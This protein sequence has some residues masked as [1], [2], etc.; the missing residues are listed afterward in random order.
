VGGARA[1]VAGESALGGKSAPF[2]GSGAHPT[3]DAP[4]RVLTN[5]PSSPIAGSLALSR[6]FTRRWIDL[7]I[8]G[9]GAIALTVYIVYCDSSMTGTLSRLSGGFR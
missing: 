4:L 6:S 5:R 8:P 9:A 2:V 1:S 7:A 3:T